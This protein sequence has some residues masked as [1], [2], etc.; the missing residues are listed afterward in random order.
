MYKAYVAIK[1]KKNNIDSSS[2]YTD[3][4]DENNDNLNQNT[5]IEIQSN[6][7][8]KKILNEIE[9]LQKIKAYIEKV[10]NDYID[11]N[12][13]EKI[14][15]ELYKH[16]QNLREYKI[17]PSSEFYSVYKN[18]EDTFFRF[19]NIIKE[20]NNTF[21]QNELNQ[22]NKLL[23][24]IDGK[25][26]DE[27]Q[28][29]AIITDELHNLIVAGAG[30][31]KTLTIAGKVKYLCET[32]N[33]SAKDI[34]LITFTKK[35]AD[36]MNDR[37]NK[38]LNIPVNAMTFHKLGLDIYVDITGKAPNIYEDIEGFVSQEL[39]RQIADNDKM[40]NDIIRFFAYY[41]H[42]IEDPKDFKDYGDYIKAI[43]TCELEPLKTKYI[44]SLKRNDLRSLEREKVKSV[45][46]A[47]IANFFFLNGIKYEYE[48]EYPFKSSITRKK[49]K[50]DFYLPEYDIYIGNTLL[51][52]KI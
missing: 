9:A 19:N 37:I 10:P 44:K 1:S 38:K 23:S 50:P 15:S 17:D 12:Q 24:D 26:L 31:G 28:R 48:R 20:K 16:I 29:I 8:S 39:M 43:K 7:E 6:E 41:I 25:S 22:H 11:F 4:N 18:A 47:I 2:L 34:L 3:N 33:I 46:E 40:R 42:L 14:K 49:Y 5:K 21:I 13:S 27:N 36:E 45:Q 52:T 32:K 30:S 35:A 51:L